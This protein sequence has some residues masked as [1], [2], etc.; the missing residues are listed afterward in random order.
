MS[1][2]IV[3]ETDQILASS[4]P[5]A[6]RLEAMSTFCPQLDIAATFTVYLA[7]RVEQFWI[8][9]VMPSTDPGAIVLPQFVVWMVTVAQLD[10]PFGADTAGDAARSI[11]TETRQTARIRSFMSGPPSWGCG[12][13]R[14]NLQ[15]RVAPMMGR[16][17]AVPARPRNVI[18]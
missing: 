13:R 6:I 17:R 7:F 1:A 10:S 4:G 11:A 8:I 2:G 16:A 12:D 14:A 9:P 3:Y 15:A 5:N 18:A